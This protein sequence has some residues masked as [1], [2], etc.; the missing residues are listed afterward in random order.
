[1]YRKD[2]N[3]MSEQSEFAKYIEEQRI[4]LRNNEDYDGGD[5]GDELVY[6][7]QLLKAIT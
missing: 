3:T 2:F 6:G 1:M 7:M 4:K 5:V